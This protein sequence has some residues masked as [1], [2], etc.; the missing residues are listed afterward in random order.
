MDVWILVANELADT[1]DGE[2]SW[3]IGI[4]DSEDKAIDAGSDIMGRI[5][6]FL[7]TDSEFVLEENAVLKN[8]TKIAW[9]TY[10]Q[11]EINK[12]YFE[13]DYEQEL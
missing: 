8:G 7:N 1:D 13:V 2:R 4:F 6:N 3:V 9:C 11:F 10:E 5:Y 12:K